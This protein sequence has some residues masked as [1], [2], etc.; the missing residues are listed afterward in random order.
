VP[1]DYYE[2]LEVGRTATAEEVK[3]A[4]KKAAKKFHPDLN[5]N[6]PAAEAKF[7]EASEAYDVLSDD[8]KRRIYDQFGHEGLRGRGVAPDFTGA[9]FQDIFEQL[10]GGGFGDLFGGRQRRAGPRRGTDL[11]M[12]MRITFME[13]AHGTSKT[14]QV[15]RRIQCGTCTGTGLKAGASVT[16][17]AT[18]GGSG[19][20]VIAQGFLRMRTPC[21][22]CRGQGRTIKPDDRCPT[23][24]GAG[25]IRETGELEVRIPAGSYPGLQIRHSGAGEAGDPGAPPGDLYVT[26]DVEPHEMFERDGADV[27]VTVPVPYEVMALGGKIQVPTVHGEESIQVRP[28]TASGHV[29]VMR[30]KGV[31]ILRGRGQRGDEHV[32]L[33]VDV[34]TSFSEEESELLRKLGELRG[35]G[36]REKGF[37]ENL[38]GK[39]G[40]H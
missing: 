33:V 15:P 4:F 10:F 11:E 29:H 9:H 25:K 20:M 31:D 13:A 2:V 39:L 14:V 24:S 38:L 16:T 18:C 5:Q 22:A 37:W 26:I 3:R 7:K 6:D 32:R 8:E 34:P 27:H 28:G 23:C 30:N 40:G 12:P 21:T 36:V 1:R 19:Q 17:C 35:S